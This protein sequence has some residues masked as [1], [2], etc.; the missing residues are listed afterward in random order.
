MYGGGDPGEIDFASDD[1]I[2]ADISY[3]Y[4]ETSGTNP[5]PLFHGCKSVDQNT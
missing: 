5:V 2:M 1:I 3:P 4:G